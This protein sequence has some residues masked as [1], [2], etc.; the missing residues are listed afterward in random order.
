MKIRITCISAG[1]MSHASSRL[2]SYYLF[3]KYKEFGIEILRVNYFSELIK[4]N[5]IHIHQIFSYKAL[6]FMFLYR[7][8]GKKIIFDFADHSP[9]LKNFLA[10]FVTLFFASIVT[11]NTIKRKKY[12]QSRLPWK[13]IV[14]IP[15]VADYYNDFLI[16]PKPLK[17]IESKSFLWFGHSSNFHSIKDTFF[18]LSSQSNIKLTVISDNDWCQNYL[19]EFKDINF[20]EWTVNFNLSEINFSGY[21]LLS[22]FNDLYGN[23]KSENKMVTSL[24]SGCIPIVSNTSAYSILAN[25]INCQNLIFNKPDDVIKISESLNLEYCNNLINESFKYIVKNYSKEH[26]LSKLIESL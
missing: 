4:G 16:K 6:F 9:G 15:D 25:N 17:E 8:L 12:W 7:I 23:Y 14:F 26:V 21:V 24:L 1:N 2:R 13:K 5:L 22:H 18:Y 3:E 19:S 20:H 11:V 10:T